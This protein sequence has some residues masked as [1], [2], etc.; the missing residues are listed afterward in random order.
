MNIKDTFINKLNI[1][2][3]IKSMSHITTD[4]LQDIYINN[5]PLVPKPITHIS[6]IILVYLTIILL[7]G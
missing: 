6:N 5:L 2:T 4:W 1:F 3:L 7:L